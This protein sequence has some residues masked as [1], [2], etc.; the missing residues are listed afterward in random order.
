[1]YIYIFPDINYPIAFINLKFLICSYLM[2]SMQNPSGIGYYPLLTVGWTLS[3]ELCFYVI[4]YFSLVFSKKYFFFLVIIISYIFPHFIKIEMFEYM[5]TFIYG[6]VFAY[7]YNKSEQL[8][9][10]LS[11]KEIRAFIAFMILVLFSGAFGWDI[12]IKAFCETLIPILF[13]EVKDELASKFK[14]LGDISYSTYLFHSIPMIILMHSINLPNRSLVANILFTVLFSIF[15]F[16]V[17]LLS[18]KYIEKPFLWK[19]HKYNRDKN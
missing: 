7:F 14:I 8:S 1:M 3:L 9:V 10:I 4:V 17:S 13:L 6:F 15:I 11:K 18:Y 2:I 19:S 5:H 12:Q 16:I